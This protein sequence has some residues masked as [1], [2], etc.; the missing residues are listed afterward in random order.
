MKSLM[1]LFKWE[2]ARKNWLEYKEDLEST[3]S[4]AFDG[5]VLEQAEKS[6]R[7]LPDEKAAKKKVLGKLPRYK[8]AV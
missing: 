1:N 5:K 6:W 8:Q 2:S 7:L 4:S 3:V